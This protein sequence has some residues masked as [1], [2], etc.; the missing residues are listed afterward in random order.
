MQMTASQQQQKVP[1]RLR[2]QYT[3][4]PLKLPHQQTRFLGYLI[5]CVC[6]SKVLSMTLHVCSMHAWA[7]HASTACYMCSS[8]HPVY[9]HYLTTH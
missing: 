3:L 2:S 9:T 7:I 5:K 1:T 4:K 6:L 8:Q